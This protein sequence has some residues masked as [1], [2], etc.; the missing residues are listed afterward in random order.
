MRRAGKGRRGR[1]V[2]AAPEQVGVGVCVGTGVFPL[3][4]L[5]RLR[6]AGWGA[7]KTGGSEGLEALG[8]ISG[9]LYQP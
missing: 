1:H 3:P 2:A 5:P 4:T 7:L 6:C 8:G 9:C